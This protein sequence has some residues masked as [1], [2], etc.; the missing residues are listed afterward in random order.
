MHEGYAEEVSSE[1]ELRDQSM[2]PYRNAQP[3][4]EQLK[5]NEAAQDKSDS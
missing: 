5:K 4:E 3:L 1:E 2:Q